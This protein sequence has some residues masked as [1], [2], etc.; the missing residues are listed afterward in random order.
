MTEPEQEQDD[1]YLVKSTGPDAEP[2]GIP[3]T[4]QEEAAEST[5]DADSVKAVADPS[6]E[7]ELPEWP[8]P[9]PGAPDSEDG[10]EGGDDP[11]PEQQ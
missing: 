2:V 5:K 6:A 7:G 4:E 3:Y 9:V 8:Y 10:D 11:H 1:P